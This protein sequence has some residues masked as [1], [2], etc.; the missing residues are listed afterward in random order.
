MSETYNIC[1]WHHDLTPDNIL[2]V[3]RSHESPYNC[4]FKI[5]DFGLAHFQRFGTSSYNATDMDQ[6]G[7]NA[8]S[9]PKILSISYMKLNSLRRT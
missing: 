2:V 9:K 1:S 5:A 8:Y 7:S 3:T 4:E 6:H